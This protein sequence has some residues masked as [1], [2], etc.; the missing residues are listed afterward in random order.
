M[1]YEVEN[2]WL[3][4]LRQSKVLPN[5]LLISRL[6]FL[7]QKRGKEA[8]FNLQDVFEDFWQLWQNLDDGSIG[9]RLGSSYQNRRN[10]FQNKIK[11]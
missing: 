9:E 6:L 11:S 4:F 8:S 2:S 5:S 1:Q 10:S 3:N 7:L